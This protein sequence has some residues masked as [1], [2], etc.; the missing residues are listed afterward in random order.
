M[1]N[2]F[3]K[4]FIENQNHENVLITT[5]TCRKTEYDGICNKIKVIEQLCD[6]YFINFDSVTETEDK[7]DESN[8]ELYQVPALN[9]TVNTS[10]ATYRKTFQTLKSR[11]LAII[12]VTQKHNQKMQNRK[13]QKQKPMKLR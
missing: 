7:S 1:S 12:Y 8:E 5:E 6:N 2:I 4:P 11:K 9:P 13:A 3:L 10:E